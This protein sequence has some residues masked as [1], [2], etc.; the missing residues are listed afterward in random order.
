MKPSSSSPLTHRNDANLFDTAN[1]YFQVRHV[2]DRVSTTTLV[3]V[4]RASEYEHF[5]ISHYSFFSLG[6]FSPSSPQNL[7]NRDLKIVFPAPK[8][9]PESFF[10]KN[11]KVF[12][13]S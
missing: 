7:S 4:R 1:I 10:F 11:P 13:D 12:F 2:V 6:E 8:T 5:Y 3:V 9:S